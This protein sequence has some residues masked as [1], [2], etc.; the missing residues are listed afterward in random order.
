MVMMVVGSTAIALAMLTGC[1][2]INSFAGT[3]LV[4]LA[5][6]DRAYWVDSEGEGDR[7]LV[8]EEIEGTVSGYFTDLPDHRF[9][10][11]KE[12]DSASLAG[13]VGEVA[14]TLNLTVAGSVLSGEL[15]KSV[16]DDYGGWWKWE[17]NGRRR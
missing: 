14:L 12:G 15:T 11:V 2:P 16:R 5:E 10:G 13:R 3:W 7:T 6:I 1:E 8:M 17:L 9:S 4:R